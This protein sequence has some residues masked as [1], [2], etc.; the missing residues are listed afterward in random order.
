MKSVIVPTDVAV[1]FLVREGA[2]K[3]Q[4]RRWIYNRSKSGLLT[5]HGKRGNGQAR[6]DLAEID[7][8]IRK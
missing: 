6:W 1:A 3:E 5:N 4:A 7:A 8:L 2:S